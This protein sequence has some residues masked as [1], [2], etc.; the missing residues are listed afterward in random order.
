MEQHN[1][2]L[3]ILRQMCQMCQYKLQ[4]TSGQERALEEVL[5]RCRLLYNTALEQRITWWCRGQGRLVSRFQREGAL[6][7]V[8]RELPEDAAVHGYVLQDVLTRLERTYQAFFRP[9]QAGYA[10]C[11]GRGRYHSFMYREYGEVVP[12]DNRS[13]VLS[14]IGRIAVRWGRPIVS[15]IK[16]VTVSREADGW[17]VSFFCAEVPTQSMSP[18][19]KE[20]GIDVGLKVSLITAEGAAVENPRHHWRAETAL[21]KAQKR[22]SRRKKRSK[23]W[24]K[25]MRLVAKKYQKG[26]RQ[27]RDFQHKTAPALV[28]AHDVLYLEG[29]QVAHMVRHRHLSTSISDAGWYQFRTMLADKAAYAGKQVVLV[30]PAYTSQEC[31]GCGTH[32]PKSL[33]VHTHLCP[34]CGLVLARDEHAARKF[35][36]RGQRLRGLAGLP[37]GMNR[38]AAGL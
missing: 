18:T 4:P 35:H 14:K 37:A 12:L 22:L 11:Q 31:S 24:W 34:A 36:W 23:R 10:R 17:Y 26:R 5:W 30:T 27:R 2:N 3:R 7:D 38:E 8:R 6:K 19:G 21:T 16:T 20:S 25:A 28:R 33:S 9:V 15:T 29:L 1:T 13:L 32:V